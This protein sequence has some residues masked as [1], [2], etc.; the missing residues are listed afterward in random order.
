MWILQ[1]LDLKLKHE[2]L[3]QVQMLFF[4]TS[5]ESSTVE[6]PWYLECPWAFH[7]YSFL[8]SLLLLLPLYLVYWSSFM[9]AAGVTHRLSHS[10]I[11]EL[12][13]LCQPPMWESQVWTA[14]AWLGN[15]M[16]PDRKQGVLVARVERSPTWATT[17]PD[18]AGIKGAEAAAL[19]ES[20]QSG[21]LQI[22]TDWC[23][24]EKLYFI[25]W[26]DS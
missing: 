17:C 20:L 8:P 12:E 10:H 25:F 13:E 7:F 11:M 6:Q 15:T 18:W 14:S 19:G 26:A 3:Q 1:S 2:W 23:W 4:M 24:I 5:S 16:A 21:L 9:T 22:P